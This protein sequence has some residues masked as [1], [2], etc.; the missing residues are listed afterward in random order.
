[1]KSDR[2][3]PVLRFCKLLFSIS[4]A[5]ALAQPT[6]QQIQQR[7]MMEERGL[8]RDREQRDEQIRQAQIDID[9]HVEQYKHYWT[10]E[11]PEDLV[12]N[13]DV[14]RFGPGERIVFEPYSK[15]MYDK[16]QVWM[17]AH[18]LLDLEDKTSRYQD[19]IG[20]SP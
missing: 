16:T 2:M 18:N 13:I 19:S 9:L 11:L 4:C 6:P 3:K 14:K 17:D 1:M 20:R 15:E 7:Q 5:L 10:R 12:E 8:Q